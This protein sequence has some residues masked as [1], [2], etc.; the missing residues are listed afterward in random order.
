MRLKEMKEYLSF[1]EAVKKCQGEVFFDSSEG[2]HLNLK[3][4]LSRYVFAVICND[5]DLLSKGRIVCTEKSDYERLEAFLE[6]ER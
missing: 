3:S 6:E 2:D 4:T 1:M 5:K